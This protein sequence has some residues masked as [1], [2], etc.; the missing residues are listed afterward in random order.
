M[1]IEGRKCKF[2]NELAQKQVLNGLAQPAKRQ[3]A[4]IVLSLLERHTEEQSCEDSAYAYISYKLRSFAERRRELLTDGRNV[5]KRLQRDGSYTAA[6]DAIEI[7][8]KNSQS[9]KDDSSFIYSILRNCECLWHMGRYGDALS[10]LKTLDKFP[11]LEMEDRA[12]KYF[13]KGRVLLRLNKYK[14][15]SDCLKKALDIYIAKSDWNG[16]LKVENVLN[17]IQRDIGN[18]NAAVDQARLL[19]SEAEKRSMSVEVH[20]QCYRSLVRS[21][22]FFRAWKE[23]REIG[24]K[25][26]QM[27]KEN[28]LIKEV[29]NCHLS[30]GE[31][32]RHGGQLQKAIHEYKDA[33]RIAQKIANRDSF[34]WSQMGL[35]DTYFIL[36][37]TSNARKNLELVQ[38]IVEGREGRYP[39]E[40]LH[41]KLSEAS[42]K[43]VLGEIAS[44][45]LAAAAND[46]NDLGISWPRN[47]VKALIN[48]PKSPEAKNL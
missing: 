8:R 40:S 22:A 1:K 14:G 31:C 45:D 39:L 32:Y 34:L 30:L 6:L 27:A 18:Y 38:A 4:N 16:S 17:T 26:L 28:N 9:I 13:L 24:A 15:S 5:I 44:G 42:I 35:A 12:T 36:S 3:A 10:Q 2:V 43:F 23:G 21:L 25:A 41:W 20:V 37:E 33:S 11:K 46:Y 47:Y 29:G 7:Y 19:V 48:H